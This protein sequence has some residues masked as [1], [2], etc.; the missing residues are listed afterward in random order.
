MNNAMAQ[1]EIVAIGGD[2]NSSGGSVSFSIGQVEYVTESDGAIYSCEGVQQPY[3]ILWWKALQ[4][5]W[6]EW[7]SYYILVNLFTTF[8]Y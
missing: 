4:W 7:P 6:R 3:E 1:Q 2:I 8:Y 5:N